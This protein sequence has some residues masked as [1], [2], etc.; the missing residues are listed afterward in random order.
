MGH[1]LFFDT[2]ILL[3]HLLDRH[4]FADNAAELWSMAERHEVTGLI[5][6]ISFNFVYYIVR[7]Q[8]D[9][10]AARRAIKGLRDLFQVVEVDGSIINDAIDSPFADFEDAIQHACALRA[11]ATH[12]VTRDVAGFRGSQVPVTSPDVYLRAQSRD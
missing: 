1:R 10:R 12:I 2:N 11:K 5:A 8:A 6:A 9:E 4:P 3:D 7:H